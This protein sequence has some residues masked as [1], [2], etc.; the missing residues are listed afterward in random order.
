MDTGLPV[1]WL[2]FKCLVSQVVHGSRLLTCR[3]K[4][5]RRFE[6]CTKRNA[7]VA[8]LVVSNWLLTNRSGVR[9]PPGAQ[10]LPE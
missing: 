2:C 10:F 4:S 7:S 6:S 5:E 8:Q 1:I 9:V 3:E